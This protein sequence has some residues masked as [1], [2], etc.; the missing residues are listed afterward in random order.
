M[1]SDFGLGK[2][3]LSYDKSSFSFQKNKKKLNLKKPQTPPWVY[4]YIFLIFFF[5][6]KVQPISQIIDE[7]NQ[8]DLNS[9]SPKKSDKVESGAITDK[10]VG[11]FY[12]SKILNCNIAKNKKF[13]SV[14]VN[15]LFFAISQFKILEV[16][17]NLPLFC[18]E[19]PHFLLYHF[20]QD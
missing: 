20:F 10:K 7:Q 19:L 12:T 17:R 13:T 2:D 15:F 18:P 8:W 16:S 1:H 4:I 9:I 14:R 11:N 6:Y 3:A 5:P